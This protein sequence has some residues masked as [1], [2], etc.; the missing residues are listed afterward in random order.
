MRLVRREI[1]ITQELDD[2]LD[3]A[4]KEEAS[5]KGAIIRREM[6]DWMR[7]R[8]EGRENAVD[9]EPHRS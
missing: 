8:R 7:R 4:R 1:L 9:R 2:E 3:I 6:L 5:S